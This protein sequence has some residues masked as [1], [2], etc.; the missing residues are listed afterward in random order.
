MPKTG[1]SCPRAA[2]LA[3][4]LCSTMSAVPAHSQD[5][6]VKPVRWIVPY[7][8]GGTSDYLAR[9]IGQKLGE[10]WGQNFVVD[11]RPG[12]AGNI[13]SEVAARMPAD[14]YT[15]L[16]VATT[17]AMNP[18]VY[19]RLPFDAEKDFTPVI[20]LV[21]Q[22]FI[23]S[24]HPSL[25]VKSVKELIALAKA[26]PGEINFGS[27]GNGTSGHVAAELFSRAAG[28]TMSHVPYRSMGH[29]VTALI[30]GEVQLSFNS[31]IS[32]LAPSKA[33]KVRAI[34][35]TSKKR[36]PSLPDVPTVDESGVPGFEEGNWQGVLMPA[37]AARPIVLKLNQ[38]I[39]RILAT[40]EITNRFVRE[41]VEVLGGPPEDFAAAIR[42]DLVKYAKLV[43]AAGIRAD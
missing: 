36:L 11:N 38:E 40:P 43:K 2:L 27:G 13:G 25:P 22:S 12:A 16:L 26:R 19:G 29:S 17:H 6:P 7:S 5:Y 8:A 4:I 10:S 34:A 39:G 21:R 1:T 31:P 3:A 15:L 32:N 41:G 37:G 35:V 33:G 28:I 20:N 24:V 23:L 9:L 30:A 18:A 42:S 14:G